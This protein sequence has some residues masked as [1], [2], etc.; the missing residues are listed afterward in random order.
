ML[1][2]QKY[3]KLIIFADDTNLNLIFSSICFDILHT[4]IQD[5]LLV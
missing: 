2:I 4:N 3:S 5:D 1:N